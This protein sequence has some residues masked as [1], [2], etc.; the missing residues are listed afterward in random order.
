MKFVKRDEKWLTE[1]A[2]GER[3]TAGIDIGKARGRQ[4]TRFKIGMILKKFMSSKMEGWFMLDRTAALMSS[5]KILILP[6]SERQDMKGEEESK[7]DIGGGFIKIF[8]F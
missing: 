4:L 6:A 1:E 7:L 8:K 3:F 2:S 5:T